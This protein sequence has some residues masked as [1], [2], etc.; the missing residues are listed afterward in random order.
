MPK[1]C[2]HSF[3]QT[4]N[5]LHFALA[6]VGEVDP[7][8]AIVA[9]QPGQQC[10]HDQVMMVIVMIIA[11]MMMVKMVM[12]SDDQLVKDDDCQGDDVF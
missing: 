6:A 11:M 2:I 8:G 4:C 7:R 10:N 12:V 1:T 5:N 9:S 3:A